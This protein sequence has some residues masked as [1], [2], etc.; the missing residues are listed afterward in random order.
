MKVSKIVISLAT[1]EAMLV[2]LKSVRKSEIISEPTI[3]S[4]SLLNAEV[5]SCQGLSGL[6]SLILSFLIVIVL[7]SFNCGKRLFP[8]LCS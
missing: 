7:G 5:V 6:P 3:F 8:D 2:V 4:T 1:L